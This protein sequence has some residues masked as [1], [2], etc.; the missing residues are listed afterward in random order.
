MM[1]I[2]GQYMFQIIIFAVL[3][4]LLLA[5][6]YYRKNQVQSSSDDSSAEL[7]PYDPSDTADGS[8][9]SRSLS[10][11]T[12]LFNFSKGSKKFMF[13]ENFDYG[14]IRNVTIKESRDTIYNKVVDRI[15]D[16][17]YYSFTLRNGVLKFFAVKTSMYLKNAYFILSLALSRPGKYFYKN[18]DPKDKRYF[19]VNSEKEDLTV[20]LSSYGKFDQAEY[21]DLADIIEASRLN[22]QNGL[23]TT[24]PLKWSKAKRQRDYF[25]LSAIVMLCSI[26]FLF[27]MNHNLEQATRDYNKVKQTERTSKKEDIQKLP[28]VPTIIKDLESKLGNYGYIMNLNLSGDRITAILKFDKE[29]N[30]H[31]FVNQIGKEGRI[32]YEQ[33]R[34]I[35]S[36]NLRSNP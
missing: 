28:N 27:L 29:E 31:L 25:V 2:F 13:F 3:L 24:L 5:A 9:I 8:S 30:I 15:G 18:E 21:E 22:S 23:P 14:V 17:F 4:V 32:K 12:S 33:N 26:F 11:L 20:Q 6:L 1:D 7:K 16:D 34:I 35:Y 36:T 19:L 10:S